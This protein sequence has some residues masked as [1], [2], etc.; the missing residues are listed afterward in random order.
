MKIV[1]FFFN[2]MTAWKVQYIIKTKG[3]NSNE[4]MLKMISYKNTPFP[5]QLYYFTLTTIF[6]IQQSYL[7]KKMNKKNKNKKVTDAGSR[8]FLFS[9]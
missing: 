3:K 6:S 9:K 4:K 1:G 7:K 5:P 8:T 2:G